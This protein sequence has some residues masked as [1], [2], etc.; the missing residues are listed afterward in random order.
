MVVPTFFLE[1]LVDES[2]DGD[3]GAPRRV[4]LPDQSDLEP[5]VEVFQALL[6]PWVGHKQVVAAGDVLHDVTLD[7]LVLQD[8]VHVVDQDRG[9]GGLEV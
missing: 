1:G 2:E 8:G 3:D 4:V 9:L 6:H 5:V 7:L